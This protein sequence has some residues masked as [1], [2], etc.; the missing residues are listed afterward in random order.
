MAEA[1]DQTRM[2][3]VSAPPTKSARDP[4]VDFLRAASLL[5]VVVWHWVFSLVAWAP[6]GPHSMNPIGTTRGLWA[7]TWLLQVMPL[8]FF[9]G[10]HA[11]LTGWRNAGRPGAFA[12]WNKRLSRLLIPTG[13]CLAVF[14][15][16]RIVVEVAYQDVTWTNRAL[17]LILSP[18]WFLATYIMLILVAPVAFRVHERV[19]PVALVVLAGAAAWVDLARF[20]YDRDGI[21]WLNMLLVWGFCHQLGFFWDRLVAAGRQFAW[22]LALAGLLA[23]SVFTNMGLY[24]RSMVGVTGER[25]SN[26]GPPTICIL[27][28][29]AFQAGVVLLLRPA[30]QHWLEQPNA[31]RFAGWANRNSMTVFLWHLTGY[32]IFYTTLRVTGYL[33]PEETTAWWWIQRPLWLIGPILGTAPLMALFRRFE[34]RAV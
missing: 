6:D 5:V 29:M 28:L 2:T 26:M 23:L 12:F 4:Y 22:S 33:A 10:G 15:V 19:G 17:L 13:A 30:A 24:P 20:H 27:A 14:V 9:V 32:A 11:H 3:R 8:F 7:L 18:L 1:V 21:A 31:A 34:R 25:F 16:V